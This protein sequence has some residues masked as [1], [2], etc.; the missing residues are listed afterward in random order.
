MIP[1]RLNTLPGLETL[2][3]D[4][5]LP[6]NPKPVPHSPLVDPNYVFRVDTL[7]AICGWMVFGRPSALWLYGAMGAGKSSGLVQLHAWLNRPLVSVNAY[8][9]L[10]WED[11][12]GS[13]EIV[14]GDTISLD[15]PLVQAARLGCTFL[16]ED[17][18]RAR[19]AMM[20]SFLS[21]LDGYPLVN[22]MNNGES[23]PRQPEFRVA[24]SA[25]SNGSGDVRGEYQTANVM[26][27]AFLDRTIAVRVEYMPPETELRVLKHALGDAIP[28]SALRQSIAFAND[29]RFLYSGATEG[30]SQ[31][32]DSSLNGAIDRT[33]S[34]RALLD[35]WSLT[36]VHAA[37]DSP[38]LYALQQVVTSKC[39]APSSAD[40]IKKLAILH[41]LG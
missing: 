25:N 23:I 7:R 35:L 5:T 26:D 2:P 18:D 19:D 14:D 28:E 15:G 4:A 32:A 10:E 41:G 11:L 39:F 17:A 1:I 37:V 12:L 33:I 38:L 22:T 20:I 31:H 36:L 40:A 24:F 29:V 30:L 3:D 16:L 9:S 27:S 8:R 13:K 34:T 21:L 6:G